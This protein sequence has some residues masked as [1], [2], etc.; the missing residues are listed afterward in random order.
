MAL[1]PIF[2]VGDIHGQPDMLRAALDLIDADA[3][4][5]APVVFLGDYVDRGPDSRAVLD[6]LANGLAEGRPWIT[7]LGNHDRYMRNFL[8]GSG[9]Q[10]PERL[11][12]LHP[13]I[14][15]RTTLESYG[16]DVGDRRTEEAIRRDAMQA[17]PAAHRAFLDRLRT[18]HL[19]EDQIFAHAGIRPGVPLDQQEEHDLIWIRDPFLMDTRDHGR[20]VVHGH[21]PQQGPVHLGNR[22]NLDGGAGFGRPLS[23]AVL[24][25]RDAWLLGKGGRIK[26]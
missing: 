6:I 24:R 20:L 18:M 9:P 17:V 12:W 25:G 11:G 5:G 19:T 1:Q 14:G 16:V 10:Y 26:L 7:L 22:L 15:G 23:A 13:N 4:T 2:A 21:T 3:D 8:N